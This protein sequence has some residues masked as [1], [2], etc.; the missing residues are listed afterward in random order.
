MQ[1]NTNKPCSPP[2]VALLHASPARDPCCHMQRRTSP[3]ALLHPHSL[4]ARRASFSS[5]AFLS[6]CSAVM[7]L[8]SSSSSWASLQLLRHPL[9]FLNLLTDLD[10]LRDLSCDAW[11]ARHLQAMKPSGES[12]LPQ[13][14][15]PAAM[16]PRCC[17]PTPTCDA[18]ALTGGRWL[19]A[20]MCPAAAWAVCLCPLHRSCNARAAL[21][22]RSETLARPKSA[23]D[24][25][26]TFMLQ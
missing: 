21:S 3:A 18:T 20:A 22:T 10:Q 9:Y 19:Q 17:S 1:L 15:Q 24:P 6:S 26:P 12:R 16:C 14:L 25:P 4:A 5:S 13:L 8:R 7:C 23:L 11:S 2:Y